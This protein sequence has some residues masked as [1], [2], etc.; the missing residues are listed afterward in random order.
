MKNNALS[1]SSVRS[2]SSCNNRICFGYQLTSAE[3]FV[4][5][6]RSY[7]KASSP[8]IRRRTPV[9][10]SSSN[11]HSCECASPP[12][13]TSSPLSQSLASR[14]RQGIREP[15]RCFCLPA[16]AIMLQLLV[17][18]LLGRFST[19]GDLPAASHD[20]DKHCSRIWCEHSRTPQVKPGNSGTHAPNP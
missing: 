4:P 12:P 11:Q 9:D 20:G 1:R 3:V 17:P 18:Y 15:R 19:T 14:T 10:Q 13:S 8:G 2:F 5:K 16:I 7:F 6:V